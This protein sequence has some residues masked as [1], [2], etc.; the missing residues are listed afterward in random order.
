MQEA[1][2]RSALKTPHI[3]LVAMA[4]GDQTHRKVNLTLQ[5]R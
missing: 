1:I 2:K 4:D 5:I 3:Q